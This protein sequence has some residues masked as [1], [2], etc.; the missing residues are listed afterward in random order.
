MKY[1]I[2]SGLG[3]SLLTV[4]TIL[5]IQQPYIFQPYPELYL[6]YAKGKEVKNKGEVDILSFCLLWTIFKIA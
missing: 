5:N 4:L 2:L 6:N 3:T 1:N